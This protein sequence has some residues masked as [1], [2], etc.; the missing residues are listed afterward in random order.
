ML[1]DCCANTSGST[2]CLRIEP[3][4]REAEALAADIDSGIQR[5]GVVSHLG[6]RVYAMEVDGFG[7]HF[8]GDDANVPSLVSLPFLG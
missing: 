5:W 1:R 3:L 4:A 8:F 2:S 7:N 6:H